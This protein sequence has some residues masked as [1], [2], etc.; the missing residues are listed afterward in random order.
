[1]ETIEINGVK[2]E[3]DLREAKKI[4]KYRVG[5]NVKLLVKN[6]GYGETAYSSY[7]GVIVGFD[8]FK[9]RPTIIIAY[10]KVDYNQASVQF[11]Y[12]NKDSKDVEVCPMIG[13]DAVI[14]KTRAIEMLDRDIAKKQQELTDLEMRRKYFLDNF[15][16]HFGRSK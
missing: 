4:E 1:M 15:H 13:E 9:E 3:V 12:L 8:A 10:L 5:D 11:I 7:P 14:D 2:L 6:P 16:K